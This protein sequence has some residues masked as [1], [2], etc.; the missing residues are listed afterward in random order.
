MVRTSKKA[1]EFYFLRHEIMSIHKQIPEAGCILTCTPRN[2]NRHKIM[3]V[4]LN[5]SHLLFPVERVSVMERGIPNDLLEASGKMIRIG[6]PEGTRDVMHGFPRVFQLFGRQFRLDA[7]NV[8]FRGN[9]HFQQENTSELR[10]AETAHFCKF[11]DAPP[12]FRILPDIFYDRY[13]GAAVLSGY[14]SPLYAP[15]EAAGWDRL[16]VEVCCSAAGRTRVSGLQ[17]DGKVKERQR[18]TECLWRNPEAMRRIRAVD[19]A[20]K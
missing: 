14:D 19:S 12:F 17:G 2:R 6:I 18:R 11:L 20:R 10:G 15:L 3:N 5:G 16:E 7:V 8:L 4:T 13:D 1:L 9:S